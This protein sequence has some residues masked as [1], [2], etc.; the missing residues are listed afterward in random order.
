[1]LPQAQSGGAVKLRRLLHIT[2]TILQREVTG[3]RRY[4][5]HRQHVHRR[6]QHVRHH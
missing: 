3:V 4:V 1:M 6:R 2:L 5:H